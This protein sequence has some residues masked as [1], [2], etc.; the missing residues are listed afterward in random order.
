MTDPFNDLL[1][2]LGIVF[3]MALHA[4]KNNACALQIK[5]G[6][7]IQLQPDPS[8]ERLLLLS[9]VVEIPPGKFREN[10]L[11]EALK[12][13]GEK[14][15]PIGIFAYLP[16]TNTLTLFQQYPIEELNGEKLAGFLSPFIDLAEKW[17]DSILSGQV[18]PTIS[19]GIP[20]G[21]IR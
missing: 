3:G 8:G 20:M 21:V 18:G 1:A 7:V 17:R 12:Y 13:N 9:R 2:S 15:F 4:D 16:K 14:L 10:V 6:L 19:K 11:K 5:K